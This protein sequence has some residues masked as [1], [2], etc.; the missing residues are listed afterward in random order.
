MAKVNLGF[1]EVAVGENIGP[2]LDSED[3]IEKTVLGV[4][5]KDLPS[6]L[7]DL[8]GLRTEVRIQKTRHGSVIVFFTVI[9]STYVVISRYKN[10]SDSV[11]LIRQH[12]EQLIKWALKA[13]FGQADVQVRILYSKYV[14]SWDYDEPT[15]F[16]DP[17]R[18]DG[19]FYYLF[20]LSLIEFVALAAL[21]YHA[22]VKTYF[23]R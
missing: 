14:R 16:L 18:R 11:R 20:C 12:A 4:L 9:L 22:I 7:F 8:F 13:R 3:E 6:D 21:L 1:F 10:F 15:Y 19:F 5:T 23:E 17:Q 2:L